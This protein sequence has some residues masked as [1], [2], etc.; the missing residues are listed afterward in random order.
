MKINGPLAIVIRNRRYM[1][2]V[3]LALQYFYFRQFS[4]WKT[5]KNNDFTVQS[6]KDMLPLP[7]KWI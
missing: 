4:G 1:Q 3:I 7:V 2:K 6:P 5:D